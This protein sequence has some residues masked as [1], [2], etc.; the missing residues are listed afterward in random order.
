MKSESTLRCHQGTVKEAKDSCAL[1]AKGKLCT[2][3]LTGLDHVMAE[4]LSIAGS[5]KSLLC[6][7]KK[8]ASSTT[9]LMNVDVFIEGL[10][11][12]KRYLL[13]DDKKH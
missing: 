11:K 10:A 13:F 2:L 1:S 4:K 7:F 5:T 8:D 9:T 3:V 12:L 6:C